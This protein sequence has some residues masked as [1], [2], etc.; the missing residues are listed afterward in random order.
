MIHGGK[1]YQKA[2]KTKYKKNQEHEMNKLGK[3]KHHDK[4][5]YRLMKEEKENYVI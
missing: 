2:E 4:S 5:F 3:Q 1:K